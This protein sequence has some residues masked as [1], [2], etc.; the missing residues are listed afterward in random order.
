MSQL[1]ERDKAAFHRIM[2]DTVQHYA[3]AIHQGREIPAWLQKQH[4]AVML[5]ES[6]PVRGIALL[7]D[8]LRDEADHLKELLY[9]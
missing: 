7:V 4:D 1:T 8:G 6:D 5:T 9:E 3:D 2:G